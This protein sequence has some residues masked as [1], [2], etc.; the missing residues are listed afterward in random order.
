M[1]HLT[2]SAASAYA[3]INS[4]A[5]RLINGDDIRNVL[6]VA[7]EA[8]ALQ[9]VV[10]RRLLRRVQDVAANV[11]RIPQQSL[12]TLAGDIGDVRSDLDERF[13]MN[14]ARSDGKE[15]RVR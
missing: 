4:P 12:S 3:N 15:W 5:R 2:L 6:D 10:S 13:R 8:D 7:D 1:E 9:G 14:N 11:R